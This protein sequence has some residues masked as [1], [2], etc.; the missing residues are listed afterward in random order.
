MNKIKKKEL[1]VPVSEPRFFRHEANEKHREVT[2]CVMTFALPMAVLTGGIVN[3]D[4][5]KAIRKVAVGFPETSLHFNFKPQA[6]A[7]IFSVKGKTECRG[8]DIP[9]QEIGDAVASAKAQAKACVVAL[10]VVTAI[11]DELRNSLARL[12]D[13]S[14][15]LNAGY[16]REVDYIEKEHYMRILQ[17]NNGQNIAPLA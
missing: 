1:L 11:K 15:F 6:P 14:E 17:R 2:V 3:E 16:L 10:R 8:N 12:H 4:M 13:I 7:I 9:R 5:L